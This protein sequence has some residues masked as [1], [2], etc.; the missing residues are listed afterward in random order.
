SE[1]DL[2]QHEA[3]INYTRGSHQEVE[4]THTNNEEIDEELRPNLFSPQKRKLIHEYFFSTSKWSVDGFA[5]AV[6][7]NDPE[8]LSK[9]ATII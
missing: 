5:G 7:T 4:G 2:V 3:T 9:K 8:C 6:F 1:S